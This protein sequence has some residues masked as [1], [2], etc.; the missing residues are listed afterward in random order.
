[1]GP[2]AQALQSSN[3]TVFTPHYM[4]WN[5]P[6]NYTS[7][8]ECLSECINGGRYCSPDPDLDPS[9]I[10]TGYSGKDVVLVSQ[11]QMFW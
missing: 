2:V 6:A 9:A 4:V 1:M 10:S 8:P 3:A 11:Q 5:C 7:T